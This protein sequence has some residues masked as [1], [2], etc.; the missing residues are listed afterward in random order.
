MLLC[1]CVMFRDALHRATSQGD[2]TTSALS[3]QL[4]AARNE[5]S[6]AH[7]TIVTLE[8]KCLE[9][10]E[11]LAA[12]LAS[13]ERDRADASA[14]VRAWSLELRAI[15]RQV[16]NDQCYV[17]SDNLDQRFD[18]EQQHAAVE[19]GRGIGPVVISLQTAGG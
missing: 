9:L 10:E 13:A 17:V 11:R 12:A 16:C 8:K 5:T 2:A 4:T 19:V 7:G 3:D 14:Q 18:G 1:V 6:K 15:I